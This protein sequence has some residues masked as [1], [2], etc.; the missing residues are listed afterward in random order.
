MNT[1]LFRAVVLVLGF[2]SLTFFTSEGVPQTPGVKPKPE[3]KEEKL[4][5]A[6]SVV[7]DFI[8]LYE[9]E[10]GPGEVDKRKDAFMKKHFGSEGAGVIQLGK[11]KY[12]VTFGEVEVA[13]EAKPGW[14]QR[15]IL[16][17]GRA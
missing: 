4:K 5:E 11:R 2:L 12:L 10:V 3:T 9:A 1:V 16:A 17:M 7:G 6:T 8:N 14:T 13:F 15:R